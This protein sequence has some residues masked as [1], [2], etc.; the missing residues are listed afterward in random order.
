MFIAAP[1]EAPQWL[2]TGNRTDAINRRTGESWRI[3][4]TGYHGMKPGG[5]RLCNRTHTMGESH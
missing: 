1:V 5:P 4:T 2:Q 3:L